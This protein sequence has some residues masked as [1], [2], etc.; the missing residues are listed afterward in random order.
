MEKS[1]CRYDVSMRNLLAA[2]NEEPAGIAFVVDE[3]EKL[4]GVVTDGDFRRM[5]LA[6]KSL[7]ESLTKKDLG[8]FV[9]ARE[10][11]SMESCCALPTNEC[12]LFRLWMQTESLLAFF[13]M[14]IG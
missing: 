9:F 2:I 4:C 6:G 3:N 14:N 10:G 5:L 11:Q 13:A 12:A 8:E 7:D 1:I